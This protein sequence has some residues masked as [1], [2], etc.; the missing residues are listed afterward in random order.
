[1]FNIF[2]PA[3]VYILLYIYECK[4]NEKLYIYI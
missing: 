3:N 1:M 2:I 4:V